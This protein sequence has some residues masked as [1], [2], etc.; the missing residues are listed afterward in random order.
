MA[1][2]VCGMHLCSKCSMI[3]LVFGLV[4][5]LDGL[6]VISINPWVIVGVY[7]GLLGIGS[8]VMKK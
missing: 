6:S 5:L 8:M 4:F 7:L 2:G 1:E 3:T